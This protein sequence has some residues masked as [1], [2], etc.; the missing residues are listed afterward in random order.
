MDYNYGVV[1][2][3][4]MEQR[5]S[6]KVM[7]LNNTTLL[8]HQIPIENPKL[9]PPGKAYCENNLFARS[10]FWFEAL[11]V[12]FTK[13]MIKSRN[14]FLYFGVT[15]AICGLALLLESLFNIRR[16]LSLVL[17]LVLRK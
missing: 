10:Q 4:L 5:I 3:D 7:G 6:I 8:E 17:G 9:D 14:P 2:I 16:Y 13:T 1:E 11:A 15:G 12:H